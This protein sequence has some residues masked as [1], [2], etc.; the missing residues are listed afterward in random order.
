MATQSKIGTL[1]FEV[2][3]DWDM[4]DLRHVSES[5]YEAYGLFY[6]LVADDDDVRTR[7]QDSLRQ[8]FWSG[9]VNSRFIGERL[10]RQ[11]PRDETLRLKSFH[12]SSQGAMTVAGVLSVLAMM[13]Y[14]ARAWITT[15]D[16]ALDLYK[17][18]EKFFGDR[19]HLQKP[20][21][22][23]ELDQEMALN[24][25]DARALVYEV[26]GLVGFTSNMCEALIATI[27]N[28]IGALKYLAVVAREGRNLS[29]MQQEGKLRLPAPPSDEINIRAPTHPRSRLKGTVQVVKI[30]NRRRRNDI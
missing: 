14:V 22:E 10:Y 2:D 30:K 7:L 24:S 26:G 17:K 3:G 20:R 4:E 28:P 13:A 9:N 16:K 18:I 8:T 15:S 1:R 5:L 25:D 27:G 12:Y 6:P 11:I 21:R 23:F 19:K 29:T